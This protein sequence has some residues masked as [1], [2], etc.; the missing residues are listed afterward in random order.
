M[1]KCIICNK[2]AK[3]FINKT[4]NYCDKCNCAKCVTIKQKYI[5][6]DKLCQEFY[7]KN[8]WPCCSNCWDLDK[9]NFLKH[10]KEVK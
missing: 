1:D 4:L 6:C 3:L 8:Y 10:K 7:I 2:K 5:F 9:E